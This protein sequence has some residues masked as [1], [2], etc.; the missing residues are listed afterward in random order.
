MNN[1]LRLLLLASMLSL[2]GCAAVV[3]TTAIVATDMATDRRTSGMYIEDQAIELKAAKELSNNQALADQ[4]DVNVIS[5]NRIVLITGQAPTSALKRQATDIVRSIDNVRRVHNEVRVK[6]PESFLSGTND[7]WLTTKSKSML[8][9][10]KKLGSHHIKV[11][12]EN[13]EVFLMGLVTRA[14][15]ETAIN[16]VREIDGVEAVVEVFEYID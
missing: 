14:E 5:Y 2:T 3:T 15:A 10:E 7:A 12:T 13:G 8:L 6:A 16:V 4:A 11:S 1:Y 9:A